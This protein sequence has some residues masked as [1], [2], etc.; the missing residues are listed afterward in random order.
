[1][2]V[3][4]GFDVDSHRRGD[5]HLRCSG[6]L[7]IR[8][9]VRREEHVTL[10]GRQLYDRKDPT[11]RELLLVRASHHVW[12]RLKRLR[13]NSD[14]TDSESVALSEALETLFVAKRKVRAEIKEL[15]AESFK[16]SRFGKGEA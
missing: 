1:M 2:R 6:G 14:G 16:R 13:R 10:T 4:G 11:R 12:A 7:F 15:A 5:L 9:L 3:E 8:H